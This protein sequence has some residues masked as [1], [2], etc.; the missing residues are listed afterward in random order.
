MKQV[1]S[2][3]GQLSEVNLDPGA[4]GDMVSMMVKK[5]AYKPSVEVWKI[6]CTSVFTVEFEYYAPVLELSLS[7]TYPC[8][9]TQVIIKNS[10]TQLKYLNS[11]C[12]RVRSWRPF[13]VLQQVFAVSHRAEYLRLRM[14]QRIVATVEDS[15]L[16]T[17]LGELDS[18][19]ED[20]HRD[21]AW[22]VSL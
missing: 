9:Q 11:H 7:T 2:R 3:V 4:L 13:Q 15:V 20:A 8:T 12:N 16:R 18:Q 22:S 19:E 17:E 6:N 1:F 14:E 21:E 10:C 5:L